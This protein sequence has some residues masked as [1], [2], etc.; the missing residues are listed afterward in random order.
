MLRCVGR[1]GAAFGVVALLSTIPAKADPSWTGFYIGAHGGYGWSDW[2]GYAGTTAGTNPVTVID[3]ANDP[4]RTLSD[5]GWFGG[6]QLG[7]NLQNGQFVFGIEGD[8]SWAD[9]DAG[10]QLDAGGPLPAS[11]WEKQHD[12][13]L[14]YFGTARARL[15]VAV[16]SFLPYVTG[17]FAWGKTSGDL[18]VAY[19]NN[20]G[21]VGTSYASA[22]ETHTGWVVGGGVEWALAGSWSLKAEYLHLDLGEADYAFSGTVFNGDPFDTDSFRSDLTVDTVRVGINY[23]LD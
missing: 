4:Y 19:S 2:D 9:I 13:S 18:A 22:D 1:L 10:G 20:T 11:L 3:G 12:L 14:D 21:L 16:G 5:E 6:A 8:I 23:Q 7:F 17:G 15:G